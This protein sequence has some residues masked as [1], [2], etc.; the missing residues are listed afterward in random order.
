[1]RNFFESSGRVRPVLGLVALLGSTAL[2]HAAFAAGIGVPEQDSYAIAE[3]TGGETTQAVPSISY[4]NPAG[5]VLINGDEVETDATYYDI[6]SDVNST[7]IPNAAAPNGPGLTGHATGFVESTAVAHAFGVFSLPGGVKAGFSITEPDAGRVK[8]P[9]DFAGNYE[10]DE[11]LLTDIQLG[12]DVA[13]PVYGGLSVGGG[14]VIDYFQS[15]LGTTQNLPLG[16][17]A[18]T[19]HG[20][21]AIGHFTGKSYAFG[22][23]VGAMYQFTPAARVGIDYRSQI[24]HDPKGNE[25]VDQGALG[26]LLGDLGPPPASKGFDN[27]LFPQ[28]VS[29]GGFYQLTPEWAVMGN[30]QWEDWSAYKTLYINDP[31]NAQT[32]L[33]GPNIAPVVE[34]FQ[35]R[36]AWTVGVA[37]EYTPVFMPKLKLMSG[38][39]YDE[40]PVP[41]ALYRV[42][43]LPDDNRVLLGFGGAYQLSPHTTVQGAYAHYF[44][45]NGGI[46]DNRTN[47]NGGTAYAGTLVGEYKLSADVFDVGLVS[48]F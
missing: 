24:K 26:A 33:V 10:G 43:G 8:Y 36:N 2:G 41:S 35:F 12:L 47:Q 31:T 14:P 39:G 11:A 21:G 34:N 5:M 30:A 13:V 9:S 28:T 19:P 44:I 23:N 6:H 29:F 48:T 1:M 46:R 25:L 42:T 38:V 7:L 32:F 4:Y 40:T 3:S 37:T 45:Q 22:Y 18:E 27:F 16:L 20:D 15:V 17:A